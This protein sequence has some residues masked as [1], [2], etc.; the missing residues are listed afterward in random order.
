[1][2]RWLGQ[3]QNQ[4]HVISRF[5]EQKRRGRAAGGRRRVTGYDNDVVQT[6]TL[7]KSVCVRCR[8]EGPKATRGVGGALDGACDRTRMSFAIKTSTSM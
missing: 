3:I 8:E 2:G 4:R 1:M 7:N 6:Q 5:I